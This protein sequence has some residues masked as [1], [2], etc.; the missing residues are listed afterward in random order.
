MEWKQNGRCLCDW[1]GLAHAAQT[2]LFHPKTKM[3]TFRKA[4]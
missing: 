4:L 3:L 2:H 1:I